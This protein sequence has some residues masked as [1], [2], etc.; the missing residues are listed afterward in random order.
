MMLKH[1]DRA[2]QRMAE[3]LPLSSVKENAI[4]NEYYYHYNPGA[5]TNDEEPHIA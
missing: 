3:V 5:A 1:P 2:D 4:N